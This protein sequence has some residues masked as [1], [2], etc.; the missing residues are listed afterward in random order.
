[1]ASGANTSDWVSLEVYRRCT[2][3]FYSA[4]GTAA[5]DATVTVLQASTNTG[6]GSKAV[7]FTDIYEKEGATALSGVAQFTKQTQ[8]AANTYVSTTGAENEQ[9]IVIEIDATDLDVAN[10]FTHIQAN[11]ADVGTN[12]QIG[13]VLYILSEPRYGAKASSMPSAIA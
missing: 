2:I 9:L 3:I 7:N 13:C 1:M 10:S 8:T 4:V 11:V 5:D 12:S 6:T